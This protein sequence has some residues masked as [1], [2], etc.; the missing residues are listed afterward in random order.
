MLAAGQEQALVGAE[1]EHLDD[2]A[3][4]GV[5]QAGEVFEL[6]GEI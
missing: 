3:E 4:V 1:G 5:E 6:V 2:R